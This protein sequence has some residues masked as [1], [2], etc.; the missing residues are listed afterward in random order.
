MGVFCPLGRSSSEKGAP[1]WCGI[2]RLTEII[3]YPAIWYTPWSFQI[4]KIISLP[5]TL[6]LPSHLHLGLRNSLFPWDIWQAKVAQAVTF[7]GSAQFESRPGHLIFRL[8]L[9]WFS[10]VLAGKCWNS[11]LN[12]AQPL[13]PTPFRI[14]YSQPY[15]HS[16]LYLLS[17]SYW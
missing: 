8:R 5:S 15:N 14:H 6:I 12:W 4:F 17:L 13:L 10:L 11:T 2:V 1:C 3:T 7:V 16:T 9:A